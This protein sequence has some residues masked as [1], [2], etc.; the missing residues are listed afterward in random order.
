MSTI[1]L[2]P[3]IV[4]FDS[5]QIIFENK[6][7]DFLT[8]DEKKRKA[9]SNKG[10]M[11]VQISIGSLGSKIGSDQLLNSDVYNKDDKIISHKIMPFSDDKRNKA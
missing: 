2:D 3:S 5:N 9:L 6:R 4:W 10:T 7:K 8:P 11:E 1:T